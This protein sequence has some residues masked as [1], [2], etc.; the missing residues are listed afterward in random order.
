MF[1]GSA[2]V[3]W[4]NT[5]GFGKDGKP[6]LVLIYTAAGNPA[7]QCLAYSTD[8]RTFTKY[9]GNPVVKQITAG[10]PRPESVLARADEAMGDGALRGVGQG[11]HHPLL[12]FA[13]PEGLD[14]RAAPTV[15]RVSGFL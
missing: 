12:Q 11:P 9:A 14:L 5:S 1:S 4:D 6:P 2:V 13:Q 10:Q 3:D 8:G 7:V 15:L